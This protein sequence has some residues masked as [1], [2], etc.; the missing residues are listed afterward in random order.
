MPPGDNLAAVRPG[1]T[2]LAQHRQYLSG[3]AAGLAAAL[4]IVVGGCAPT[5][6]AGPAQ[7][8]GP[9]GSPNYANPN[10]PNSVPPGYAPPGAT[11]AAPGGL[12]Q[13]PATMTYRPPPPPPPQYA[14]PQ[15]P[16][17][18]QML[19]WR[20]TVQLE[21]SDREARFRRLA[22]QGLIQSPQFYEELIS[23]KDLPPEFGVDIPV[24]RVVFPERVFFETAQS[25]IRPDALPTIDLIAKTLRADVPDV[26][27]FIAGHTDSRGGEAYNYGLSLDRANAVAKELAARGV[28]STYHLWSI[29]FGKAVPVAKNDTPEH[30][31]LNRRV[32]V[33]IAARPQAIAVWL[34]RQAIAICGTVPADLKASCQQEVATLPPIEAHPVQITTRPPEVAK[35]AP[36]SRT[37][38]TLDPNATYVIHLNN[39][40]VE[41]HG[42]PRT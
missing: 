31:A 8:P 9:S 11:S 1:R 13:Q 5:Y 12:N 17:P 2:P 30:M 42:D 32:E 36:P 40:Q 4:L 29:G 41:V 20:Q 7:A 27:V 28:G 10:Y 38:L 16:A 15:G 23:G 39:Q 22:A 3:A 37:D 19:D 26:S 18:A 24:L 25:A 21:N 6:Q 34:S 33:L 35:P 14:P